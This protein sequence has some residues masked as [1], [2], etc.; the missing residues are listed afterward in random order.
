MIAR[1]NVT[2]TA[3]RTFPVAAVLIP[4]VV[5]AWW[6][7]VAHANAVSCMLDGLAR[8]GTAMPFHTSP[9]EFTARWAVMMTAMMLP[10]MIAIAWRYPVLAGIGT[11]TGYMAVWTATSVIGFGA[12]LALNDV[13][14][15]MS[16]LNRL[17]GAVIV[18]AGLYQISHTKRRQLA[19]YRIQDQPP[20]ASGAFAAGLSHGIRCLASSCALM[21]VL[22]V[23]GVMN[24]VWMT[25]LAGICLVE[26]A[27]DRRTGFATAVGLTLI[28]IGV[29]VIVAP[30]A[31]NFIAET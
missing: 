21:S 4:V 1:P 27:F 24:L 11:A 28:A 17:G 23:V 29:V 8:A 12:L 19:R 14:R 6:W 3:Q 25:A 22:L 13:D 15:P 7:T 30:Q 5:L 2:G 20:A 16:W 31:L 18:V 9:F 10:G 26:K